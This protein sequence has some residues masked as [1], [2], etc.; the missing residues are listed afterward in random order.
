MNPYIQY[1]FTLFVFFY[2][3]NMLI[4][5]FALYRLQMQSIDFSKR[6]FLLENRIDFNLPLQKDK[7]LCL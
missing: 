7:Y 6:L 5:I 2:L 3:M 4:V 1:W